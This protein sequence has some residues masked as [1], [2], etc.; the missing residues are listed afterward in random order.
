MAIL[1]IITEAISKGIN[2]DVSDGFAHTVIRLYQ[3][4][5]QKEEFQAL[6]RTFG[7]NDALA[8]EVYVL[9]NDNIEALTAELAGAGADDKSDDRSDKKP[10]RK[11]KPKTS[12]KSSR[13]APDFAYEEDEESGGMDLLVPQTHNEEVQNETRASKPV[14]FKKLKKERVHELKMEPNTK[15]EVPEKKEE[16]PTEQQ[17][18]TAPQQIKP[19][20]LQLAEMEK[21]TA[22]LDEPASGLS[23][24]DN[25]DLDDGILQE[26]IDNDREWYTG[27]DQG[28]VA[29]VD[30]YGDTDAMFA[31]QHKPQR[32]KQ[33]H[34]NRLQRSGGGFDAQ[35]GEY[36]DYDHDDML[37]NQLLRIPITL[38]F[39]VP[40]FLR[41]SEQFLSPLLDR[42]TSRGL[43]ASVNPV[44]DPESELALAARNGSF[45][46][47][48]RKEK[49]ERARQS[50]DR[51]AQDD[52]KEAA[53][54][55]SK[56]TRPEETEQDPV[57]AHE[58]AK[59]QRR[60]LPAYRAKLELMRL[61]EENQIIVVVGETGSGKTTQ[62]A[63]FLYE[64]GYGKSKDKDGVRQLIGCTQPRRVAAMSV[65]KRVAVEV[66]CKVGEEVGFVIRFE[67]KTH[68]AKTVI[69]YM[70]EGI[71]LRE[72]LVDPMLEAYSCIIMDEAHERT[73]S[74]DI[75]LGLFRQLLRRR[76]DLKLVVTSATLNADRF[77]T[78]F[79]LAP[80]FF[81]PGRTFPVEVLYA[82]SSCSDY[83]DT[84][85]KQVMTIHL[86]NQGSAGDILV[87]MTGQEDIETTCEMIHE[88]LDMLENP[89]P[90]D[91][92]PIYSSL[93]ADAQ[94]KI[95]T[96][97]S[98]QR[99]KVVVATN[100][101]ETSLTVDG[102]KYVV[103]S[104][105]VKLK[106]FNPK[107]GMDT[108]QVVPVSLAN[109]QQ[110]S[111]RAGRT[112][113]GTAYR[114]Y[115]EAAAS[116]DQMHQQ[117]IPEIHRA[118]LTSVMLLLKSLNVSDV[119]RFP[120]LDPPPPDLLACSLY[121][122]W[123]LGALDNLGN[124]TEMGTKLTDFPMEPKLA[125]LMLLSS[126]ER[127]HCSS[128]ILTVVSMLSVPNVFHRPKE[129]AD[130][131]DTA[132]E[133][134]MISG[135][136]HL[137]LLN[138]YTQWEQR[139]KQAKMNAHKMASWCDRNFLNMRSLVRA[140]DIRNQLE[141]IMA[142][143]KYPVLKAK[144]D[145][146]IRRCL[147]ATYFHQLAKLLKMSGGRGQAEYGNLRHSYM[148][149]Y[150]HPTSA[151]VGGTDLSPSF[152][153]YDE[154]V[155]T[156]KEYMQC[157]TAVEPEWLLE[158][159]HVFFGVT[160]A[161]KS[162]IS[163]Y[164]DFDLVDKADWEKRLAQ[165]ASQMEVSQRHESVSK[166]PKVIH[167]QRRGF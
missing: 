132:H 155:L 68:P 166:K 125:K 17:A 141:L 163:P 14:K 108:L 66:G 144:N 31:S 49:K 154:L 113:P 95:F 45:V 5:K 15:Q 19:T 46:V 153:I 90:L 20:L 83:V 110:R 57:A 135:L 136:D 21:A 27:E 18:E 157:A 36:V 3:R 112:G 106:Q 58:E 62:I 165:D 160:S 60:E 6:T 12:K 138:V 51:V 89:P 61:I 37:L 71:L 124:L 131:A 11:P 2:R 101:A 151:L 64:A 167:R 145:T 26:D 39:L 4:S 150:L 91:V 55:T 158:Y 111:G 152:V 84:A 164:L 43:G 92:Y 119:L 115:T 33:N 100:I 75:L 129:R 85:V 93:P 82:R 134:F 47:R 86:A 147:C 142:K 8:N 139:G 25:S 114:L 137:T 161:T 116:E 24:W 121:D 148:K 94:R 40:P 96:K 34:Q 99:R 122:L 7:F 120:F 123:A 79:G 81:I 127:F 143:K 72:L 126:D 133:R 56:N 107:L 98:A 59:V 41:G 78:F 103:D 140:R 10:E 76:K 162:Q 130:D 30:D 13:H 44:K 109:A 16:E 28:H 128:E 50:R 102:I 159:G 105:L 97:L 52:T 77:T 42:A 35:T 29:I 149:M 48:D 146:D 80:Q 23:E 118:N 73:L 22:K 54:D 70:T 87:F 53:N 67:D 69:K 74:T 38:H 63:Q 88:K 156:K 9:I 1:P 104:G 65:A 32:G 117:P